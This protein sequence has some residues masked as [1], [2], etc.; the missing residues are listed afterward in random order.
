MRELAHPLDYFA[1]LQY[2][3]NPGISQDC[4][5]AVVR[6]IQSREL[7]SFGRILSYE[8]S[9]ALL[10]TVGVGDYVAVKSGFSSG[11]RGEGPR[12]FSF[13]LQ[14]LN[15]HGAECDEFLVSAEVFARLDASALTH[16]DVEELEGARPKRPSRWREYIDE[17]HWERFRDGTLWE[18]FPAV[19][20]FAI[21]DP[22]LMD[23]ALSFWEAPSDRILTGYK[24]LE[25]TVRKRSGLREHGTKLFSQAFHGPP[26]RLHWVGVDPGEHA[27][28]AQLFV[29]AFTAFRNPRA[30]R[31][32]TERIEDQLA[33][34]L[35]LN[36]LFRLERKADEADIS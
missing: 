25:D 20:P 7:I 12:A 2:I 28:R 11:Y 35:V 31:E 26:P 19:L 21:I 15:A 13:V 29:N 36:Q 22:R 10:L 4:V 18:D 27:G 30:H 16:S 32:L 23:L 3:G 33:E 17:D 6:L 5:D 24:R 14:L 34:F 1:A 8:N 9:H